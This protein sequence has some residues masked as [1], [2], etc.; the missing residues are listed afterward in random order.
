MRTGDFE[1]VQ[2]M[3][4]STSATAAPT[5]G[6]ARRAVGCRIGGGESFSSGGVDVKD[7]HGP[8]CKDRAHGFE[9]ILRL[10]PAANNRCAR[11][12]LAG[13]VLR[14]ER[15]RGGRADARQ[16]NRVHDGQR[17]AVLGVRDHHDPLDRREASEL[18]VLRQIDVDLRGKGQVRT[19]QKP[20]LDVNGSAFDREAHGSTLIAAIV[21]K[22][23][24]GVTQRCNCRL[25]PKKAL[26]VV[27]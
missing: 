24:I 3:Q 8:K 18:G 16:R 23:G 11:R 13:A 7:A 10:G 12:V 4:M 17:P 26:Q 2:V 20:G 25:R 6:E 9:L 22:S 21:G 19:R 14:R 5:L 15:R 27:S 1:V